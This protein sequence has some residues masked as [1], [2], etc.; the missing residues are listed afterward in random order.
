ME[1]INRLVRLFCL[2]SNVFWNQFIERIYFFHVICVLLLGHDFHLLLDLENL[3]MLSIRGLAN[4]I[5][6]FFSKTN[7]E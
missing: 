7:T 2:F 1:Q 3:L 5:V 6:V 4:L